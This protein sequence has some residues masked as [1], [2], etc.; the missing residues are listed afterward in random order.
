MSTRLS[1][2]VMFVALGSALPPSAALA[3]TAGT[4]MV[5]PRFSVAN[6]NPS[7]EPELPSLKSEGAAFTLSLIGT[8]VPLVLG[9]AIMTTSDDFYY[10]DAAGSAGAFLIYTGLYFGPSMGYFYAGKSGRGWASF[11]LR[12]GIAMVSLVGAFAICSPSGCYDDNQA[13]AARLILLAAGVG[14]LASATYD[15]VKIKGT[16]RERNEK[17][18]ASRVALIPTYS[19]ADGP[20]VRVSLAVR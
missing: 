2:I 6:P 20:G 13:T 10:S 18:L 7:Q 17:Q 14:I 15:L 1:S 16:V 9:T 12:N 3:Q 4:T 19:R 11:G 8:L 5:S